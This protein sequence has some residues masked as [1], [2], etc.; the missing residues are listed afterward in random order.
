[1]VSFSLL[2]KEVSFED[3]VWSGEP[4]DQVTEEIKQLCGES[5]SGAEE[6]T[7]IATRAKEI[8]RQ[9][10]RDFTN[11][12]KQMPPQMRDTI[13]GLTYDESKSPRENEITQPHKLRELFNDEGFIDILIEDHPSSPPVNRDQLMRNFTKYYNSLGALSVYKFQCINSNPQDKQK[14]PLKTNL[15]RAVDI[16]FNPSPLAGDGSGQ[17]TKTRPREDMG[18]SKVTDEETPEIEPRCQNIVEKSIALDEKAGELGPQEYIRQRR[19]LETCVNWC[20]PDVKEYYPMLCAR[21]EAPPKRT[22]PPVVATLDHKEND[23]WVTY[24]GRSMSCNAGWLTQSFD[25]RNWNEQKINCVIQGSSLEIFRED[26]YNLLGSVARNLSD[27]QAGTT[28]EGDIFQESIPMQSSYLTYPDLV[29]M[30]AITKFLDGYCELTG[31]APTNIPSTCSPYKNGIQNFTCNKNVTPN[32][33]DYITSSKQLSKLYEEKNRLN[34]L[35]NSEIY[36]GVRDF[37]ATGIAPATST[38]AGLSVTEAYQNYSALSAQIEE[39]ENTIIELSGKYPLLMSG[40]KTDSPIEDQEIPSDGIIKKLSRMDEN[41]INERKFN[42]LYEKAKTNAAEKFNT[43]LTNICDPSG[44]VTDDQIILIPEFTGPTLQKFPQYEVAQLCLE[45]RFGPEDMKQLLDD[46]AVPGAALLC[47]GAAV[48]P[49]AV[50]V[51]AACGVMFAGHGYYLY[52]REQNKLIQLQDCRQSTQGQD[53]CNDES[54]LRQKSEYDSALLN[55]QISLATLPLDVLLPGAVEFGP[56]I[57]QALRAT[58]DMPIEEAIRL[59]RE[60]EGELQAIKNIEDPEAQFEALGALMQKIKSQDDYQPI[61]V[62]AGSEDKFFRMVRGD[63]NA[64]NGLVQFS[65]GTTDSSALDNYTVIERTEGYLGGRLIEMDI[66]FPQ[67]P[68]YIDSEI[69]LTSRGSQSGGV[70]HG[71]SFPE[72]SP[73]LE[74]FHHG[75]N[76]LYPKMTRANEVYEHLGREFT[77][78]GLSNNVRFIDDSVVGSADDFYGGMENFI[79][80]MHC[81]GQPVGSMCWP[82]GAEGLF[83]LHD[84]GTHYTKLYQLPEDIVKQVSHQTRTVSKYLDFLDGK[85]AEMNKNMQAL[86]EIERKMEGFVSPL[87]DYDVNKLSDFYSSDAMTPLER[88]IF[89]EAFK[90]DFILDSTTG[91][92][93]IE[94]GNK[95]IVR[96]SG[97]EL[98]DINFARQA[99]YFEM[100]LR[101]IKQMKMNLVKETGEQLET[102]GI[103]SIREDSL[104]LT[105]LANPPRDYI[106]KVASIVPDPPPGNRLG[107]MSWFEYAGEKMQSNT[108]QYLAEFSRTQEGMNVFYAEKGYWEYEQIMDTKKQI[109]EQMDGL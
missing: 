65:P 70:S 42:R 79:K 49:Q 8:E 27:S 31:E 11:W 71:I 21:Q 26:Y 81:P 102:I 45:L 78:S 62:V 75:N 3:S 47:L 23:H 15:P 59:A 51:G 50:A 12:V 74:V 69:G 34:D 9:Y 68:L 7:K 106:Q 2:C 52:T 4:I 13:N 85:Y 87:G 19:E 60:I 55:L 57:M 63:P 91:D 6:Q 80:N 53:V 25:T 67:N 108:R 36:K 29:R 44:G 96:D 43:S 95:D 38:L 10:I 77:R 82:M 89:D 5:C 101:G 20:S 73:T 41:N 39:V 37:I 98:V 28:A 84:I 33:S 90:P 93:I 40:L 22:G 46:V 97:G 56:K 109:V 54:Y 35:A 94:L 61:D 76:F 103:G 104:M 66:Q 99:N 18:G 30:T 83:H 16:S 100:E 105:M 32:K 48:G 58:D 1:M 72:P 24:D 86:K 64:E 107:D 14:C 17:T 92:F 88:K